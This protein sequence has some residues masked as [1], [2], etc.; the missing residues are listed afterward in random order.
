MAGTSGR[1]LRSE[2]VILDGQYRLNM[3][4]IEIDRD[5][6]LKRDTVTAPT[7]ASI[8]EDHPEYAVLEVRCAC[9]ATIYLRCDYAPLG[10][11]D[12]FQS[13]ASEAEESG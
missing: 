2:E 12:H 9:G 5:E 13:R 3:G 6:S 8:L 1:I 4:R 11:P 10:T 7:R